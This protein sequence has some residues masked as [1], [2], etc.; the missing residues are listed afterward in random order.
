MFQLAASSPKVAILDEIDSGLDIDAV[1]EVAELV[2]D[3]RSPDLGLLVITHYSRI[4]RYMR[5]DLVHV[6]VAGRIVR[7]GGPEVA[8]ELEAT[9]YDEL[10]GELGVAGDEPHGSDPLL[11]L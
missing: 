1:R 2:E 8:E 7:T 3:L 4:L 9:G 11:G 5:P 10:R 6:M